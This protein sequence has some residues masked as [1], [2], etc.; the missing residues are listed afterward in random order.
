[1][2]PKKK[3]FD[4]CERNKW[5]YIITFKE[6]ALSSVAEEFEGLKKLKD[7]RFYG[8]GKCTH[9]QN[10][11]KHEWI[12]AI[13][14][15]DHLLNVIECIEENLDNTPSDTRFVWITNIKINEDNYQS[16][17]NRGGRLRWKI[18]N[19]GFNMQKNGGYNLEHA[20]SKNLNA[21]KNFYILMQ[22]AHIIN[23]LM[24]YGSLLYDTI[25]SVYG[26]IKNIAKRLLEA[27]RQKPPLLEELENFLQTKCQI[28][29]SNSA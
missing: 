10:K 19:Q 24:E 12:N 28:R 5:K 27:L 23:Q 15:Q 13:P 21:S 1:L 7:K 25:H 26:S 16:I 11:Q 9:K 18:E 17:A 20:Y 8:R 2:Y 29:F 3:V 14:Y 6:D 22:I 4:I